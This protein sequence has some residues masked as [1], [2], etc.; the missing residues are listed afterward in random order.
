MS[1]VDY[2]AIIHQHIAPDSQ[3]Y[4]L[5]L[6]HVILVANAALAIARRLDLDQEQLTFIEEASMLHDIGISNVKSSK[7]HTDSDL[8]YICHGVEGAKILRDA[9]LPRHALVA[10][11]HT[12]VG[13]TLEEVQQHHLPLPER[14]YRP[15]SLEEEIISYADLFF[16]KRQETLWVPEAQEQI[17][18]ELAQYGE[19]SVATF[20]D[21]HQ[22]FGVPVVLR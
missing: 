13:I 1:A 6:P 19:Q 10:E 16:S 12:G 5:Y 22:R 21:W 8:P 17:R 11:R 4:Q 2:F 18:S 3:L 9:G 20:D 14:D 15:Q 7:W